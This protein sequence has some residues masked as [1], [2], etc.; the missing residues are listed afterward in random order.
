MHFQCQPSASPF[1]PTDSDG[2]DFTSYHE[3]DCAAEEVD[4][5]MLDVGA[6]FT[7][8]PEDQYNLNVEEAADSNQQNKE[9]PFFIEYYPRAAKIKGWGKTFMDIFDQDEHAS[10]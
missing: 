9:N 5:E 1:Q 7:S 6:A 2:L 10:K 3:R 8:I 4:V